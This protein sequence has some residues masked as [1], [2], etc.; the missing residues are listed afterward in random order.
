MKVGSLVI[1][2]APYN[3]WIVLDSGQ[4][5]IGPSHGEITTI[6]GFQDEFLEFM[7]YP[8]LGADGLRDAYHRKWFREVQPPMNIDIENLIHETT[9]QP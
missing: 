6:S 3:K 5:T 7:E 8:Q 4:S 2:E 9:L 1:C